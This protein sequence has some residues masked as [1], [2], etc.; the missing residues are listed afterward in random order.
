[1]GPIAYF[2]CQKPVI[3]VAMF[4]TVIPASRIRSATTFTHR[5][6]FLTGSLRFGARPIMDKCA[7]ALLIG[8]PVGQSVRDSA[9]IT[10][11]NTNAYSG[12]EC[13][14]AR[15]SSLALQDGS[16]AI[17]SPVLYRTLGQ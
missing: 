1:M 10:D 13:L 17:G 7:L 3:G 2:L 11:R 9:P 8:A 6:W 12:R 5:L 16:I 4:V 14:R 15:H